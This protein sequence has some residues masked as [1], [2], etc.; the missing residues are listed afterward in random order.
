[1]K[2]HRPTKA[3]E[4]GKK[5]WLWPSLRFVAGIAVVTAAAWAL[6]AFTPLE[7][8]LATYTAHA[9]AFLLDSM[10]R[11]VAVSFQDVPHLLSE[12]FDA[13][14]IPLCWGTFEIAL[15]AGIVLSTQNRSLRR[16]AH[17]LMAG[18]AA[19]LLFNPVRIALTLLVF[20]ASQPFASEVAHDALFRLSLLSLFVI[21]YAVWYQWP[22]KH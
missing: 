3:P 14:L 7:G 20:D 17:G 1:M 11:P 15:W 4:T 18:T 22:E 13:E 19:F 21:A 12:R 10:G 6:L 2:T 8:Y 9:T 5:D 16:R